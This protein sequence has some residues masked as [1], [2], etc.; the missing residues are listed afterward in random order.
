MEYRQI[1]SSGLRVSE[2]A[3]GNWLTH[4]GSV[5]DDTAIECVRT[6][7]DEG[8]TFFDTADIYNKGRAE[9]VLGKALKSERRDDMVV[10]SKVFWPM[11]DNP[12]DQ[13]L[14][15]KH[16]IQSCNASL[17][18]LGMEYLDL[19]QAHRYDDEVPIHET[20][21][22]F[23]DLVRSGKALYIGVSEWSAT[24]IADALRIADEM[25][26]DRLI[27]NQPQYSMLWRVPEAEVMPLC[28]K[29]GLGQVVW[30]PLAMGVL[31]GKY[32][33]GQ[34]PPEGTRGATG[35]G[36][37]KRYL[38]DETLR[39]VEKLRPIADG[40]G[41]K[42]STLALAWVLNNDNVAA[43]IVGATRPSQVTE[44]VSASG[45]TLSDEVVRRIDD[46]LGEVTFTDPSLTGG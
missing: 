35:K 19:Y 1:G 46:A 32:A 7:L 27:S 8:I 44:N 20:L 37:N 25:G 6:A 2:I 17:K 29:E 40:L 42:M 24:Q 45:V 14:S 9:T 3:L 30:S 28:R 22:A 11:S 39:A 43:A 4:G 15:R 34:A 31:T 13:G 12:N 18:R 41:I 33:P 26:F 21:R 23:D 5:A 10:A 36:L 38:N 16:I